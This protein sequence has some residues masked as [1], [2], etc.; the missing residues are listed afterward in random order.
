[1]V[2]R[3]DYF[4][5]ATLIDEAAES[6]A[7]A[8]AQHNS[9]AVGNSRDGA[10]VGVAK[11]VAHRFLAHLLRRPAPDIAVL[12]AQS[13]VIAVTEAIEMSVG[14]LFFEI[15]KAAGHFAVNAPAFEDTMVNH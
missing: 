13:Q 4:L 1:M 9:E 5:E 15:E 7:A 14:T 6:F 8:V 12:I 2:S 11:R 3:V 10:A